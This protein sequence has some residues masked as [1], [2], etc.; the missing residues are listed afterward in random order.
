MN[1]I[2]LPNLELKT[3][4]E[5]DA[6]DYCSINNINSDNIT[7]LD[8]F[9]NEL[10]DIS[11]IKLFKNLKE[12]YINYN[13]IKDI[14]VIKNL[15]GLEYLNITNLKLESD[16]IKYIQYLNNLEELWCNKGFKDMS[17]IN[18]LNKNIEIYD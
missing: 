2:H 8:L 10:T 1:K 15:T 12:L 11:G 13:K 16:Q 6:L 7:E 9:N 5:Q 3:F 14:S 17:V 4:T 18:K